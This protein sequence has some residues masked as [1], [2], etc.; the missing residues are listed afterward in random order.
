VK[1]ERLTFYDL[2]DLPRALEYVRKAPHTGAYLDMMAKH[3][4]VDERE[5]FEWLK[6]HGFRTQPVEGFN[7]TLVL[8][9]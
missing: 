6:L 7:L 8:R 3:F 1:R 4:D 5:L 9:K 2:I